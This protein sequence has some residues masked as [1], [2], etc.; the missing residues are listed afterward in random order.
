MGHNMTQKKNPLLAAG[1][2]GIWCTCP[3]VTIAAFPADPCTHWDAVSELPV[4]ML[5]AAPCG[6]H[7]TAIVLDKKNNPRR[8]TLINMK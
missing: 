5:L 1:S 2:D 7:C 8:D 4:A 3:Y 6:H